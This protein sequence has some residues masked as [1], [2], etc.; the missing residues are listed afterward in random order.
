MLGE[1]EARRLRKLAGDLAQ[2]P[3]DVLA[4]PGA[5]D[6]REAPATHRADDR[7]PLVE[8]AFAFPE[9]RLVPDPAA[10]EPQEE[11]RHPAVGP[12][13]HLAPRDRERPVDLAVLE[14]LGE[15]H[16]HRRAH[17]LHADLALHRENGVHAGLRQ[18]RGE[19]DELPGG[20]ER[21]GSTTCSEPALSQEASTTSR[22]RSTSS[23]TRWANSSPSATLAV[24]VLVLQVEER[25]LLGLQPAVADEVEDVDA[26]AEPVDQPIERQRQLGV[27]SP[28]TVTWMPFRLSRARATSAVDVDR[29]RARTGRGRSG[30]R[31]RPVPAT[32]SS[33]EGAP[34]ASR[35][36]S[37][38]ARTGSS[39][40][41]RAAAR[42]PGR[43]ASSQRRLCSSGALRSTNS[44]TR[45]E[46]SAASTAALNCPY[47]ARTSS[48]AKR[49]SASASPYALLRAVLEQRGVPG[50][51]WRPRRGAGVFSASSLGSSNRSSTRYCPSWSRLLS[52][53]CSSA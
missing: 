38:T 39:R 30:S 10:L 23:S 34:G 15:E 49:L 14:E 51:R 8:V 33:R 21:P 25:P 31:R 16:R 44:F 47:L 52:P 48:S 3:V 5:D 1:R 50:G 41:S 42:C 17:R 35:R 19:R 40:R 53:I 4:E 28:A 20:D 26:A 46:P 37:R 27:L 7:L 36:S 32:R 11:C 22:G 9:A 6:R 2:R 18:R 12:V 43:S 45:R 24:A 29:R 13:A